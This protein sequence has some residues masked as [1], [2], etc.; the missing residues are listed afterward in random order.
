MARADRTVRGA[1][2][3][4]FPRATR[5][6]LVAL[7]LFAA[8]CSGRAPAPLA[9]STRANVLLIALDEVGTRLGTYGSP[10]LTPHLDGLAA[11]GRRFDRAYSQY[12]ALTPSRLAVL[13]GRRPETTRLWSVPESRES[14]RGAS[15]MPE[16]FRAQAY[17]TARVGS[18]LG[19]SADAVVAWDRTEDPP[20]GEP[21]ATARRAVELLAEHK[22]GSFLLAVGFAGPPPGALPPA[23][24]LRLYDPRSL[25]LPAEPSVAGLPPLALADHGAAPVPRPSPLPDAHRRRLFAAELAHASQVDAQVGVLLAEVDRLGLRDRT[26]VVVVGDTAPR[27]WWTRPD[28]LFEESLRSALIVAGP[29][30]ASPGRASDRVV[31]MVDVFPTLLDLAGLPRID[32]LDGV[33]LRPLLADPGRS[34]KAA[35][36]SDAQRFAEPLGRSVRTDRWRYTE[37]PDGSRELYDHEQDAGE[38]RNLALGGAAAETMRELQAAL[39]GG[40]APPPKAVTPAARPRAPAAKPNVLLV[41]VDDLN[42]RLGCYGYPVHSPAMDRLARE[43]RR[44]DRAYCQ[45]ASCSP[46]RTSLLTGWRPERTGVWD[47]L[48]TP[49]ERLQGAVPLQE[50]FHAN[51]YFTARV[52]KI[53]HGPFEEQFHW[54]VAEHTPYLPGDEAWEPPSRKERERAGS[55]ARPW[56]ATD[57]RDQDEPDGRTARRVAELIAQNKG[58]PF[59]IAAGFNKPHIHWVAPRRYFDLYP[60]DRIELPQEPPDDRDDIPEIAIFRKAPR[61]PGRFL[62][63]PGD[64]DDAFRREATAAYYAC[65][66]FVD[67]QVGVLLEALER[68]HLRERTIVVLL[69]DHGYHLGE[70]GGLWRKNT[71]FEEA[72]RV[73]FIVAAPGLERPGVAARGLVESLD[74]YPT[75]IDLAGLPAV[76]GLEGTSLRP[77]LDDPRRTV[78][79][80]ALSVAPRNPPELGRSAR[81]ERWRYTEWPDGGQELYDLAAPGWWARI[82]AALGVR[83]GG[84]PPNLAGDPRLASTVAEMKALLDQVGN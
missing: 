13:L 18:L 82:A 72:L 49:R 63:G 42:V 36:V 4:A 23:E 31:E 52:G 68:A 84:P 59:F 39:D 70:H 57:N 56:T 61:A 30:V 10:A 2:P 44:F 47:N 1:L 14:L 35:A 22:D 62:G 5:G 40:A 12:P 83:K 41:M 19:A 77:L 60:P 15:S 43:G 6:G 28:V 38:F 80:A 74:L 79:T 67:A 71:L 11:R 78:K 50:H 21:G 9:L 66:S 76:S 51:G 55:S 73:P 65:V 25:A 81:S 3:S 29:G 24:Y 20:A 7:A 64:P 8:G 58:R 32:G 75:L 33:S 54:D 53:Y 16:A 26:V 37:W 48:Q 17:F 45:I 27:G 69:G 34:V 46:S